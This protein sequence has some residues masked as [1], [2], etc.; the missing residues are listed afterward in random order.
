MKVL[1]T[2]AR[3]PISAD[4][5]RALHAAGH[6][7][8]VTDS[9]RWPIGRF[10]PVI[11]AYVRL[12]APAVDFAAFNQALGEFCDQEGIDLI[13]PTSEE[14]FWLAQVTALPGACRR[15]LP[16]AQ[17]LE[18]LH[19]KGKFARLANSLGFGPGACHELGSPAQRE[20]FLQGPGAG[21]SRWV[22]KQVYS[23]FANQVLIGP[24][25]HEVEQLTL[26]PENP[27]LAQP[28]VTGQE[29]CVYNIAHEGRLALHQ[30]YLPRWRAGAG[31]SVYFE[32]FEDACLQELSSRVVEATG[33]TG[34]ISFD[35]MLTAVGPVALECNPRGTSGVHLAA[36][37][38]E[39]LAAALTQPAGTPLPSPPA[40][41]SL[42]SRMLELALL[43][44]HPRFLVTEAGRAQ[45]RGARDALGECGI[46]SRP[47]MLST[48]ELLW[49]SLANR[50]SVT[51]VSTREIEWNGAR[52]DHS[53]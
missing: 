6:R 8:W 40:S 53:A 28:R 33:F 7:V 16:D 12:P 47:Q 38:A 9:L 45:R 19:H 50:Q 24:S 41:P 4:L 26:T 35:V 29:V 46:G 52:C 32:P 37:R 18:L 34:Q 13:V 10:S 14:V 49:L 2:G 39:R 51:R 11:E 27:W 5:A 23:R 21:T 25:A 42:E 1:I 15:F 31:A 17:T 36:Q 20:Q 48:L 43:L 22:F 3:A 44:Y 30:A